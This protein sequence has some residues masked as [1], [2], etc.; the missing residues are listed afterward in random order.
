M[1]QILFRCPECSVM[2][3]I[4]HELIDQPVQCPNCHTRIVA[5]S[6]DISFECPSCQCDLGAPREL[7]GRLADCPDCGKSLSIPAPPSEQENRNT[8]QAPTVD[9]KERLKLQQNVG[10]SS[11]SSPPH[12]GPQIGR[13][14]MSC[15]TM[16][17]PSAT[18]CT[19]CG[20]HQATG[21]ESSVFA[22]QRRNKIFNIL[23]RSVMVI[24][25]GSAV[26]WGYTEF[27]KRQFLKQETF[28]IS[29]AMAKAQKTVSLE[30]AT[31]SLKDNIA[32]HAKAPNRNEAEQLLRRLE[33]QLV[34]KQA[35][36]A[37]EQALSKD[38]DKAKEISA[39]SLSD[40]MAIITNALPKYLKASNRADAE[41]LLKQW[42]QQIAEQ[43][44]IKA[45][46]EA[47]AAE[48]E[49]AKKTKS[50]ELA[51]PIVQNA[52]AKYPR[53]P[54]RNEAEEF[55]KKGLAYQQ[56]QKRLAELDAAKKR[57]QEEENAELEAA[58]KRKQQEEAVAATRPPQ[59]STKPSSPAARPLID[60]NKSLVNP[61]KKMLR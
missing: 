55:I 1:S 36:A 2:L 4:E 23:Q 14:C 58:K 32:G 59:G 42:E 16:L 5:P 52:L 3:A 10:P 43:Q 6:T 47:L 44:A 38:V 39:T 60:P 56:E 57:K 29:E 50:A 25:F 24:V 18:V 49:R 34:E 7:G 61:S 26:A 45:E 54:N 30:I 19:K 46:G 31:A 51:I 33:R 48:I 28:A 11:T 13:Y 40:A 41:K 15:G 12:E 20:I 8:P 22:S 27:K 21:K 53:A 17:P 37:E 9:R 35:C